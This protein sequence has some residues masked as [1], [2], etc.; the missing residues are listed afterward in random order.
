MKLP[1]IAKIRI[2]ITIAIAIGEIA[3]L[4]YFYEK[5]ML[6][7]AYGGRALIGFLLL[8]LMS[9]GLIVPYL[10]NDWLQRRGIQYFEVVIVVAL[11]PGSVISF[12]H[13]NLFRGILSATISLVCMI[14]ILPRLLRPVSIHG[15][16]INTRTTEAEGN[17]PSQRTIHRP[18]G[19]YFGMLL[20]WFI[21]VELS[22]SHVKGPI[23]FWIMT[24]YVLPAIWL[25]WQVIYQLFKS[26][27][28]SHAAKRASIDQGGRA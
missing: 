15:R 5:F 8:S 6:H 4:I 23:P 19:K 24:L 7:P 26:A 20:I 13:G 9:I 16:E 17:N 1:S 12:T 28:D 25:V 18:A 10:W 27:T 14:A 22:S 21:F 2:P 3:A 11:G